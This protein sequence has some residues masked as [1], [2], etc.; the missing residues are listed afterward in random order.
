M[1]SSVRSVGWAGVGVGL[2]S[3]SPVFVDPSHGW[4]MFVPYSNAVALALRTTSDGGQKWNSVR[5]P[6]EYGADSLFALDARHAWF[7]TG[8]DMGHKVGALYATI[9]GGKTWRREHLFD[10]MPLLGVF[11]SDLR[12][13]WVVTSGK[14]AN[15]MYA[16]SDGGRHW[17]E[18]LTS[19]HGD[20]SPMAWTFQ[21]AGDTLF[22]S[23]G[24]LTFSRPLPRGGQ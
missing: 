13:G 7:A 9:N 18:E 2:N 6:Y 17:R 3:P 16:T 24:Y 19:S 22:A 12:H 23:N 1:S 10:H 15:G 5:T 21:T 11:F 14:N 8:D 20:W 4:S